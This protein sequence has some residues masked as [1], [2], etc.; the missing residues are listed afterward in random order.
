M[1]V[2]K[3]WK[4]RFGA[5]HREVVFDLRRI[6]N[7]YMVVPIVI[8]LLGSYYYPIF[9]SWL[10]RNFPDE[11]AISILF[12][13]SLAA[14]NLRLFLKEADITYLTPIENRIKGFFIR[15]LLYNWMVKGLFVLGLWVIVTPFY[16]NR[17]SSSN[18]QYLLLL[19]LLILLKGWNLGLYWFSLKSFTETYVRLL[20]M[21]RSI[22]NFIMLYGLM[23]QKKL[24]VIIGL[25]LVVACSMY[26]RQY[27]GTAILNWL[28][29][30]KE[31]SRTNGRFTSFLRLF[32]DRGSGRE[33]ITY[34][35]FVP[36]IINVGRFPKIDPFLYLYLKVF[37]RS[38]ASNILIRIS[39]LGFVILYFIR[40]IVALWIVYTLILF[41]SSLQIWAFLDAVGNRFWFSLY[42]LPKRKRYR[43][44]QYLIVYTIM[45]QG[46]LL[47]FIVLVQKS[48]IMFYFLFTITGALVALITGKLYIIKSVNR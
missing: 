15:A 20:A 22:T 3:L 16:L 34:R 30:L 10:P 7:G 23:L 29:L 37:L 27:F 25:L 45:I 48:P 6:A 46:I 44:F 21:L 42:P 18:L 41:L 47:S 35:T 11:F 12:A 36:S 33:A 24:I 31:E 2:K 43:S 5:F 38:E 28:R 13:Y 26:H 4:L 40:D 39:I 14:G 32:M 8:F 9:L 19:L 1:I 17:I